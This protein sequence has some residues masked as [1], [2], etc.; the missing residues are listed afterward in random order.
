MR[1]TLDEIVAHKRT[2]VC[3]RET[4]RPLADLPVEAL[5]GSPFEVALQTASQDNPALTLEVKPASPSAGVLTESLNLPALLNVYNQHASAL[6]VLTDKRF[7]GGGFDVFDEVGA[8]S[9]HPRL[10]KDFILTSYQ[11]VEARFHGATAV[12]LI[13]KILDDVTLKSLY[14]QITALGMT[15]VVEV[16]NETELQRALVL[17]PRVILVNNR[18]LD[19]FEISL[20]TSLRLIPQIP[21][22]VIAISASG[23]QTRADIAYLL[24][25]C[26]RF[27]I[28]SL[29][30]KTPL[31]QLD[32]VLEE[33][34][35][36]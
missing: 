20:E 8:L 32:S 34:R 14:E 18:N 26:Q 2:E 30:M 21:P 22:E 12:L 5:T 3:D 16:Q 31:T 27:L 6:S 17:N 35:G 1:A 19:T 36:G 28:G 23:I 25:V 11:V 9:P 4:H 15:A 10:C 13:V 33:L 29:L 7:F 24:P